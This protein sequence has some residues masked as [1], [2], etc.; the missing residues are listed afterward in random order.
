MKA[1]KKV[2]TPKTVGV[3]VK[4]ESRVEKDMKEI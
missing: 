3:L 1:R 4:C 2:T